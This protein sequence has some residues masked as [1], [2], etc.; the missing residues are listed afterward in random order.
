[1][2]A[3]QRRA[4]LS[5]PC[6]ACWRTVEQ[7]VDGA[8]DEGHDKVGHA[9]AHVAPASCG[10]VNEADHRLAVH[11]RAPDLW[12]YVESITGAGTWWLACVQQAREGGRCKIDTTAPRGSCPVIVVTARAKTTRSPA[13]E[14]AASEACYTP[15]MCAYIFTR[16]DTY[17]C[18]AAAADLRGD[19]G[20][21]ADADHPTAHDEAGGRLDKEHAWRYT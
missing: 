10:R 8:E 12:P 3:A 21:E 15:P 20:G 13:E 7:V 18:A 14:W 1:M 5:L 6:R 17:I 2:R 11:L 16:G 9:A 19:E 4:T